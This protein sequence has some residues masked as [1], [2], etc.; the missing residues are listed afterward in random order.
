M[1]FRSGHDLEI[2][3]PVIIFVFLCFWVK[4]LKQG[5]LEPGQVEKIGRWQEARTFG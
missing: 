5:L 4:Y 3:G 2:L 1:D